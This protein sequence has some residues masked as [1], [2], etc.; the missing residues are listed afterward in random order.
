MSITIGIIS[1][2]SYL[3]KTTTFRWTCF[4]QHLC[5]CKY[6]CSAL[7]N[8]GKGQGVWRRT[9]TVV[10]IAIA[11]LHLYMCIHDSCERTLTWSHHPNH[12][13]ENEILL[14]AFSTLIV[15]IHP[16]LFYFATLTNLTAMILHKHQNEEIACPIEQILTMRSAKYNWEKDQITLQTIHRDR[17]FKAEL[18]WN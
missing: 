9:A 15:Y 8:F 17:S 10:T 16:Y 13:C 6:T 14:I 7:F 2:D 18:S 4:S 3:S 12:G 1:D 5:C 11:N